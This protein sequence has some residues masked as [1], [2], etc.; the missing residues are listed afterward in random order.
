M[1]KVLFWTAIVMACWGPLFTI[2]FFANGG[3]E[4]KL[5]SSL[6]LYARTGSFLKMGFGRLAR[7]FFGRTSRWMVST[8][9]VLILFIGKSGGWL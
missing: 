5:N 3:D 1:T 2:T 6:D 9:G 4:F 8:F 7:L